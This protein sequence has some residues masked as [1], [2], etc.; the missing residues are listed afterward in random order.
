MEVFVVFCCNSN[1]DSILFINGVYKNE[2]EA[3]NHCADLNVLAKS[4]AI[5]RYF[6][7]RATVI[8]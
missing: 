1:D 8:L 2:Q 5:G 4:L 7:Y 3:I 6:D